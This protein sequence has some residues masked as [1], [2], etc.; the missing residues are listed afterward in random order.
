[1]KKGEALAPTHHIA[2]YIRPR[3]FNNGLINGEAFLCRPQETAA[4]VNWL[5]YFDKPLPEGIIALQ[6]SSPLEMRPTGRIVTLNVG[7]TR[8]YI[9]KHSENKRLEFIY[10]PTKD[11]SHSLIYNIPEQ[12]T[13]EAEFIKDLLVQ[14]ILEEY[15]PH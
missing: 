14:C 3:Y 4:S 11:P 1:M 9:A 13:P 12:D 5:E 8:D 7:A 15:Q 10:A 6:A 2:R